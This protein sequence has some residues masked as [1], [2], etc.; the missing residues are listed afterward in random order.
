MRP[1]FKW[2]IGI[3]LSALGVLAAIFGYRNAV[4]KGEKKELERQTAAEHEVVE[5]LKETDAKID[6]HTKMV[7]DEIKR[8]LEATLKKDPTEA[9]VKALIEESKDLEMTAK[10]SRGAS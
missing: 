3:V 5:A 2:I 4:K 8:E 10:R 6:L 9:E 7:T 1:V